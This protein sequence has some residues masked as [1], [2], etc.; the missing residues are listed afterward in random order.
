[1]TSASD[2]F[3]AARDLMADGDPRKVTIDALCKQLGTTSGSFYHHFGSLEGF[4]DALADD[5]SQ[6]AVTAMRAAIA[7]VANLPGTRRLVN[8]KILLQQHQLEAAFRAWG[9]TNE[10]MRSAVQRVDEA[11]FAASRTMVAALNPQLSPADVETCAEISVL[12]LIGAQAHDPAT[13][14]EVSAAALTAFANLIERR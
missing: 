2:Y 14:G 11:R 3:A 5:W 4:V 7:D 8:E 10:S 6:R 9:R 13:A 12:I 1:M